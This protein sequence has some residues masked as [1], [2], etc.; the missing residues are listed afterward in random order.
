M[1]ALADE[2]IMNSSERKKVSVICK[3]AIESFNEGDWLTLGQITGSLKKVT[4]HGRLL[5]SLSFG[6]DDYSFSAAEVLD[7]IFKSDTD[8]IP[9]VID[10]FDVDLWYSQKHPDKYR[11]VFLETKV[12]NADFWEDG[13][14]KLF[15]SHLSSNKSRMSALKASLSNWGVCAFIAHEDVEPS[16]E[17]R[18]E[19][20]AALQSMEI[21]VAVVEPG[22]KE[23]DWCAQEVGYALGRGIDVIPLCA[24][25]EPFGF[26][27]K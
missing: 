6:D 14:L 11:R 3:Y 2:L 27:G 20:E 15:V 21:L 19:V 26:F 4:D 7:D 23:S 13:Y 25:L 12:T 17:W 18:D 5:R 1:A 16:R 22:F 24:G 9:D 8:L 10:H